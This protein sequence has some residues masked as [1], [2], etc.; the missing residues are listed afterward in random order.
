MLITQTAS[1]P[2]GTSSYLAMSGALKNEQASAFDIDY[3]NLHGWEL[4]NND[5]AEGTAIKKIVWTNL[6]KDEFYKTFTGHT[7]NN[8][9][10]WSRVCCNGF[11]AW[12]CLS[13][14]APANTYEG[15]FNVETVFKKIFHW[16]M[17]CRIHLALAATVH[18]SFFQDIVMFIRVQETYHHKNIRASATTGRTCWVFG[19]RLSC[20][21]PDY[22]DVI[23]PKLIRR[24][25]E[26]SAWC[27]GSYRM[28][29]W[30]NVTKCRMRSLPEQL[31]AAW[32]IPATSSPVWWVQRRA[33]PTPTAFIQSTHN[34]IG[35][36]I[37]LMLQ[38]HNYNNAFCTSVSLLKALY[39]MA[40]CY[41]TKVQPNRYLWVAL[42]N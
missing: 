37:G 24:M 41:W 26:S 40:W 39:W 36:Q 11:E 30:T 19:N 23:D 16:N 7:L 31:M 22:K 21:E 25:A 1:S 5:I 28:S 9:G 29:S 42:M 20:T 4:Q 17:Y 3:I 8:C 2:D 6:S 10:N 35:A 14:P 32:K 27:N 34:T 18:H 12:I 13:Q 38:C 33:A 15:S